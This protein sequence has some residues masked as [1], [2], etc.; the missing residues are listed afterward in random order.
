MS[1]AQVQVNGCPVSAQL[2][3]RTIPRLHEEAELNSLAQHCPPTSALAAEASMGAFCRAGM[4]L[5]EL[6]IVVVGE[7]LFRTDV[8]ASIDKNPGALFL[9]LA[10]GRARMID[11]TG[12]VA[13][14]G[15]VDYQ[16]IL[17][18]EEHRVGRMLMHISVP[19]VRL[20]IGD[21]FAFVLNDPRTF[22]DMDQR[23]DAAAVNGGVS[24]R[25]TPSLA[26]CLC[27]NAYT[28]IFI[29]G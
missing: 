16:I 19:T 24:N 7:F 25:I 12:G 28:I 22:W 4:P 14:P 18:R 23:E 29:S 5:A 11:P 21:Q 17:E 8:P 6:Q 26:I 13:A 15:R 1:A 10:I 9:D 20:I 2:F 27:H 3:D